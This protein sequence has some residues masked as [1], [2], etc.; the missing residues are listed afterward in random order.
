VCLSLIVCVSLCVCLS[1]YVCLSVSLSVS[2]HFFANDDNILVLVKADQFILV[3]FIVLER[4]LKSHN[5][6][7]KFYWGKRF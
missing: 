1:Y 7:L 5:I 4:S 3:G 2:V 6:C